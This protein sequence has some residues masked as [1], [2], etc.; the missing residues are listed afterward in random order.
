MNS[1]RPLMVAKAGKS[2]G[3][4]RW[5]R[6]RSWGHS[7]LGGPPK[8][9]LR[10]SE[11]NKVNASRKARVRQWPVIPPGL[12]GATLPLL[13]DMADWNFFFKRTSINGQE[14]HFR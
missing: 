9:P 8:I 4:D 5:G 11:Q 7:S 13:A 14:N 1:N 6:V 2:L 12:G 3:K 10:I